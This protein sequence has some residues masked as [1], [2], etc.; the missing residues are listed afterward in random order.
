MNEFPRKGIHS[1]PEEFW[2]YWK[3]IGCMRKVCIVVKEE[4]YL[5]VREVEFSSFFSSFTII[6]IIFYNYNIFFRIIE[7]QMFRDLK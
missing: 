6:A 4:K 7:H 3:F 5:C 1:N 2:F